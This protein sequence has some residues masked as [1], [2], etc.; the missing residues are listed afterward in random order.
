VSRRAPLR[1]EHRPGLPHLLV[2]ERVDPL[3]AGP[4][5]EVMQEQERPALEWTAYPSLVR[6]ELGDDA[7]VP[8][9]HSCHWSSHSRLLCA[10][11]PK[12]LPAPLAQ[13]MLA[14]GLAFP[15]IAL[16]PARTRVHTRQTQ[17]MALAG[18]GW[19][20]AV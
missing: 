13:S 18:Q 12:G 9:V 8:I 5:P 2:R 1:A 17:R 3:G 11:R 6:T 4:R 10:S 14:R 7:V 15:S 16:I 20:G 19:G